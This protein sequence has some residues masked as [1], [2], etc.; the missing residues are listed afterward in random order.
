[1]SGS[2]V[3]AV[4]DG[5]WCLNSHFLSLGCKGSLRMTT[6][7]TS[8]GLILYSPVHLDDAHVVQIGELGRVSVIVAPNL[9]HHLFLRECA[10]TFRPA[11]ILLPQGLAE[12]IGPIA[13]SEVIDGQTRIAPE[14][15]IEQ[16]TF[17]GHRIRETILYH[18]SSKTLVTSDL[19][20]NYTTD[21]FPS[22]RLWFKM[23]G[24]YGSP[25]VAFYHRFSIKDKSS[26][27]ALVEWV[28][29]RQVDRIIM[30]H[31]RIFESLQA[32][33]VFVEAWKRIAKLS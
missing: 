10:T 14:A 27:V 19:I 6:I 24:C 18:R 20:Y 11:R 26:A 7:S 3:E 1:M 25:K 23:I 22:E 28:R 33:D 9:Y 17:A 12:K 31:G 21:Q 13:G 32:G 8:E 15:E 4:T 16:F 5:I 2:K 30:S 29:L